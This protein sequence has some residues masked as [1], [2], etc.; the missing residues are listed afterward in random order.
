MVKLVRLVVLVSALVA[1]A[2]PSVWAEP[3]NPCGPPGG[4]C[5]PGVNCR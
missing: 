4:G 3:F 2:A 1:G 5:V